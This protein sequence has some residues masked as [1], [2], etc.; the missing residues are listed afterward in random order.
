[1]IKEPNLNSL[2]KEGYTSTWRDKKELCFLEGKA[3]VEEGLTADSNP[4]VENTWPWRWFNESF[5]LHADC[6]NA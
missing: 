4:Y 3:Y 6:A 5:L 1:M 2:I